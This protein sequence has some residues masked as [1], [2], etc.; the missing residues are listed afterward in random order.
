MERYV[1]LL[2]TCNTT[3]ATIVERKCGGGGG[4]FIEV[5]TYVR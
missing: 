1:L 4:D 3:G 2:F 5:N